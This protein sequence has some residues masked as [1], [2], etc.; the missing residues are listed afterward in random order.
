[1][2]KNYKTNRGIPYILGF[3][4]A[5]LVAVLIVPSVMAGEPTGN[6]P[7]DAM[8][9]TNAWQTL[10]P[11]ASRWLYFDYTGDKSKI[12]VTVDDNGA[13][14][15]QV[16]IFTPEQVIALQSDPTIAPVGLASLPNPNSSDAI[17]DL[18][19]LG[20]FNFPGRF[21][22]VVTNNQ[23]ASITFR[24]QV[25]GTSVTL[26][27]APT[28]TPAPWLALLNLYNMPV[29]S[30]SFQGQLVFQEASGGNIYT[31]NG[32]GSNLKRVTYG[33]DPAWSP[34][35]KQIAFTRWNSP[36]G[37]FI[38]NADGSNEQAIMNA[39][40]AMSPQW[41]S[42][43]NQIAFAWQKGGKAETV[44]CVG[45]NCTVIPANLYWKIGVVQLGQVVDDVTSYPLSEP[46]CTN[47]CFSP[48][49]SNDGRYIA[50][51]E[52]GIGILRTDL[53]A[54]KQIDPDVT[55]PKSV[56]TL[57]N[58]MTR[59]QSTAYSPDGKQIAFQAV[60]ND[61]WE[62]FVMNADGSNVRAL[63][64]SKVPALTRGIN[65]VA[66]VWSPNGKEILFLSDRN[67][68]WEFFVA[69]VDGSNLRQ[70]LKSVTDSI[71]IRYDFS[72]ERVAD[73]K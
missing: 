46:D 2:N 66:P 70:V 30:G 37:V 27:P 28:P 52:T 71:A 19:W 22:V 53:L 51:A 40:Q 49:W 63:L 34:D 61:R 10:A 39:D 69:S 41:N 11:N 3:I 26:F 12:L 36:T 4:F 18:V 62:V 24:L 55:V 6:N 1:M 17:H 5:M 57:F 33:L 72:N 45:N 43:G 7:S 15:L 64:Q 44:R 14:N 9:V 67:G 13:S 8:R 38:A 25:S 73:W 54:P 21:F 48:T 29:P 23:T 47:H 16:A 32:D 65:N 59:V 20:A 68:K 31:V 35:G 50:F 56:T 60:Q 58:E 42:A